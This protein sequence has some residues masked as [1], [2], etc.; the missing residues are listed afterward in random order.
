MKVLWIAPIKHPKARGH[1]APWVEQL[2]KEL[3]EHVELTIVA[4]SP[5]VAKDAETYFINNAKSIFL[6]ALRPKIDVLTFK[7]F[8]INKLRLWLNKN[9]VNFD[10][11]HIHGNEHQ[12]EVAAKKLQIPKLISIQGI[13]S[14]IL[15]YFTPSGFQLLGWKQAA[16]Y[17]LNH[18]RTVN[19]FSCR[20]H[21]D[22]SIV[23]KHNPQA[24]I[25]NIWEMIRPEFFVEK[26]LE[27]GNNILFLGG[28]QKIKG[29]DIALKTYECIKDKIKG[30]L[31]IGGR[32]NKAQLYR[33]IKRNRF[34][35]NLDD[36]INI[37]GFLDTK[38]II[39]HAQKSFCL[40]HPTLIDNSPNSVCEAQVM[41]LPVIAS[42]VGGVS[43]LIEHGK[44]G[45]LTDHNS[46]FIAD[47]IL[48]LYE[49][50]GLWSNISIQSRMI[51]R[52]RH[53]PERIVR[54]TIN[55]YKQIISDN[56]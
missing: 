41:G 51:A 11:I 32:T 23:E 33:I 29:I 36:D 2:A 15:N 30:K 39:W 56:A 12:F 37:L 4:L 3:S 13:I 21:W 24:K 5:F 10:I 48:K 38:D 54:E 55:M 42:D 45:F 40:L 22:H 49:D 9:A 27:K 6:K 44:T 35:L 7:L 52:E 31:L 47:Q 25:Y 19:N 46:S 50:H 14:E 28:S 18:Y 1:P 20:T 53:N 16:Y 34:D 26:P 8:K 43:S 17:E